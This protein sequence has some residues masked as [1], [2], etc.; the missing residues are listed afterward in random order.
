M[1]G[2]PRRPNSS[3]F[4]G[5]SRALPQNFR[6]QFQNPGLPPPRHNVYP[7]QLGDFRP[8]QPYYQTQGPFSMNPR[9][10]GPVQG[11]QPRTWQ[12]NGPRQSFRP[13]GFQ[14][15]QRPRVNVWCFGHW[16]FRVPASSQGRRGWGWGTPQNFWW[17]R[18]AQFSKPWPCFRHKYVIFLTWSVKSIPVYRLSIKMVT[19]IYSDFGPKC[20]KNH[21]L[22]GP[23]VPVVLYS[24]YKGVPPE[25]FLC[26]TFI[27]RSD[28]QM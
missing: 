21:I 15:Q 17:A 1:Y 22:W 3:P 7:A 25:L 10:Q 24:L 2:G 27:S 18:A 5:R 20:L 14:Q 12:G 19:E 4:Q 11:F 6:P 16:L 26:L 28:I 8:R 23:H 9:F 13:S